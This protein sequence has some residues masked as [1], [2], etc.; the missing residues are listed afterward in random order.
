MNVIKSALVDFTFLHNDK[1]KGSGLN[2]S[3]HY[4]NSIHS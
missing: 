4:Q 2:G 3:V 1:T